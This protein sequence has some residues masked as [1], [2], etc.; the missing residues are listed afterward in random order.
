MNER[1]CFRNTVSSDILR[2][3]LTLIGY[4]ATDEQVNAVCITQN[5][6]YECWLLNDFSDQCV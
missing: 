4:K 2:V 6:T 3:T 1:T 5:S